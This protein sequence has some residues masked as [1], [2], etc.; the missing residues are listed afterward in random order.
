MAAHGVSER[1][2]PSA[3]VHAH[4]SRVC[5]CAQEGSCLC[6]FQQLRRITRIRISRRTRRLR[7]RPAVAVAP[8]T[9]ECLLSL[10]MYELFLTWLLYFLI[11]FCNNYKISLQL[12]LLLCFFYFG[13]DV[14]TSSQCTHRLVVD[15]WT[16]RRDL[17][18]G[19]C[20][21]L[22]VGLSTISPR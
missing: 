22:C 18:S 21:P 15:V 8:R 11:N 16:R 20:I 4:S 12:L 6:L 1:H 5:S 3:E 14:D 13:N 10:W 9:R 17:E 2:R 19:R 7:I